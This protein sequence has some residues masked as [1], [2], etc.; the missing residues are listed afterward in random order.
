[1]FNPLHTEIGKTQIKC[2]IMLYFI[3]LGYVL[4]PKIV[5]ISRDRDTAFNFDTSTSDPLKYQ[6]DNPIIIMLIT[7]GQSSHNNLRKIAIFFLSISLNMCYESQKDC[8]IETVLLSTHY[9][10]FG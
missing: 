10:C 5:T 8:L 2:S 4:F 6:I 7:W 3:S 1:M 9:I